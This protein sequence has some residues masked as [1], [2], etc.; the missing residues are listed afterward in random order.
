MTLNSSTIPITFADNNELVEFDFET[1][2]F[3]GWMQEECC[4]HSQRIVTSP[5]RSGHHAVRFEVRDDDRYFSASRSEIHRS[6]D[7][8]TLGQ[9][10][11][12]GFSIYIPEEW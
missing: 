10:Y 8:D 4:A 3:L 9:D 11:W 2:D 7:R 12:Y 6:S 5:V 1:G